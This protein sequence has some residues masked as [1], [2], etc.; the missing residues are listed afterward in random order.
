M[1]TDILVQNNSTLALSKEQG[2]NEKPSRNIRKKVAFQVIDEI[3]NDDVESFTGSSDSMSIEESNNTN[4]V[5]FH[6]ENELVTK[7]RPRRKF[8]LLRERFEPKFT[9]KIDNC[10]VSQKKTSLNTTLARS[11]KKPIN[12]A[13]NESEICLSPNFDEENLTDK[14]IP[15]LESKGKLD[16]LKE[17]RSVFLKQVLSPPRLQGWGKKRTFS[18]NAK[19]VS[20][21][22]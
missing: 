3:I 7:S 9:E 2:S 21:A 17:K 8:S 16:N 22:H 20:K 6:T 13:V 10:S 5:T 1:N 15:V 4:T 12:V 19:I 18:P 14:S 11:L